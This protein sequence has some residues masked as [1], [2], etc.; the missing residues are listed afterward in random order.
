MSTTLMIVATVIGLGILLVATLV[1][2]MV[3]GTARRDRRITV[4]LEPVHRALREHRTPDTELILGLAR[5]PLTRNTLGELLSRFG[6]LAL[7]PI[8][9]LGPVAMAESDMVAW[10][11]HPHELASVPDEIQYMARV[12]KD[13]GPDIGEVVWFVFRFR[14][15]K[16]RWAATKGWMAGVVGPYRMSG[17][18]V[19]TRGT[20]TFSQFMAYD[21]KNPEE[22]V[23]SIHEE[24]LR[25][26][27]LKNLGRPSSASAA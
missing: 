4:L 21:R 19:L 27:K 10:L 5:N 8:E 15:D 6:R 11:A 22:H 1:L 14:A 13:A 9:H 18:R 26:G 25:R 2:S 20:A 12:V 24:A 16:P 23:T 7:F 3:F 17:D